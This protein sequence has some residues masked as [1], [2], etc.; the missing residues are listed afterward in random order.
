[1]KLTLATEQTSTAIS[2]VSLCLA[3]LLTT[4]GASAIDRSIGELLFLR[5]LLDRAY[6]LENTVRRR[7]MIS[8][9]F[10]LGSDCVAV[11]SVV[12]ATVTVSLDNS[13][14]ICSSSI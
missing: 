14:V 7:E 5:K 9:F 8:L 3:V 1:M 13:D 2:G 12:S 6:G 10:S 11:V 4:S